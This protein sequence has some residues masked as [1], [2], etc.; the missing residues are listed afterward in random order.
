MREISISSR[1]SRC[2]MCGYVS[3]S[4]KCLYSHMK[5]D[6][7]SGVRHY[8]CCIC[9]LLTLSKYFILKHV[10]SHAKSGKSQCSETGED[11]C[12]DVNSCGLWDVWQELN[13]SS[14]P[15]CWPVSFILQGWG[16]LSRPPTGVALAAAALLDLRPAFGSTF[17]RQQTVT[18]QST[19]V[20]FVSS[21]APDCQLLGDTSR[22]IYRT[23]QTAIRLE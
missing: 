15:S 14:L 3:R 12:G 13:F 22:L 21:P 17:L 8:S 5:L 11:N 2:L 6:E 1:A 23:C 7:R 9:R 19:R 16:P 20:S 18:Q 4:R 10:A